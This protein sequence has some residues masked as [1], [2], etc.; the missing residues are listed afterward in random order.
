MILK[1]TNEAHKKITHQNIL[2]TELAFVISAIVCDLF[3]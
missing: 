1:Q 3:Y 2:A